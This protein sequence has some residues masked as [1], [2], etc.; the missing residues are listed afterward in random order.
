MHEQ[1]VVEG[2]H[3]REGLAAVAVL[4]Q[5]QLPNA[6]LRETQHQLVVLLVRE[7][8]VDF[9]VLVV[10]QARWQEADVVGVVLS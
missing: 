9:A 2:A 7:H 10:R 3:L 4:A 8:L 5:Q 6:P 1:V